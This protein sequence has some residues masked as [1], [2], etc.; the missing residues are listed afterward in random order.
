MLTCCKAATSY[1]SQAAV[2]FGGFVTTTAQNV[3]SATQ[4]IIYQA[5]MADLSEFLLVRYGRRTQRVR[6]EEQPFEQLLK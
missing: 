6:A 5:P 2:A 4:R 1:S 3:P